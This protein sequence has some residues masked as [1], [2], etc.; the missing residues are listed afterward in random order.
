MSFVITK[1][2]SFPHAHTDNRKR[3][4]RGEQM[5]EGNSKRLCLMKS[6]DQLSGVTQMMYPRHKED[7]HIDCNNHTPFAA[8]V[9]GWRHRRRVRCFTWRTLYGLGVRYPSTSRHPFPPIP[10]WGER[11]WWM[12]LIS[13]IKVISRR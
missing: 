12:T 10:P 9:R 3:K 11:D 5:E 4:L 2:S 13:P 1:L 8:T 6:I 7:R